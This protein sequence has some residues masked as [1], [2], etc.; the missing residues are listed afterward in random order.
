MAQDLLAQTI[1]K[2]EVEIVIISKGFRNLQYGRAITKSVGDCRWLKRE[3]SEEAR[4]LSQLLLTYVRLQ[5]QRQPSN[6]FRTMETGAGQKIC[7]SAPTE[8]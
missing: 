3:S 5:P 7:S 8:L 1:Y 2:C 6:H 4:L